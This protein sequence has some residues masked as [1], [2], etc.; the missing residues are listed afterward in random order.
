MSANDAV[1]RII[2]QLKWD[3]NGLIPVV[4]QD[5]HSSMVLMVAWT[6]A[7]T[8]RLT[9]ETGEMHF[10]SRSRGEIWHKGETSGNTQTVFQLFVDCDADTLLAMVYPSG[11]AC[12]TGNLTCFYRNLEAPID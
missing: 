9:F 5:V 12:H 10:W 6:N 7:E 11:P 2:D 3:A 4:V 1:E 8:L